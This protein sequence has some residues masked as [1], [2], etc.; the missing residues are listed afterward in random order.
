MKSILT[1]TDGPFADLFKQFIVSRR[2]NAGIPRQAPT[3]MKA[4]AQVQP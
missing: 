2:P 1:N 4:S 3:R